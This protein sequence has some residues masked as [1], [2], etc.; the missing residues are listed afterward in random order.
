MLL[1]CSALSVLFQAMLGELKADNHIEIVLYWKISSS[2]GNRQFKKLPKTP[3]VPLL[4]LQFYCSADKIIS[5]I[6]GPVQGRLR[7]G[8][9]S[10]NY[11]SFQGIPYARPPLGDL[12]FKVNAFS[13]FPPTSLDLLVIFFRIQFSL[14]HGT[15]H[16]MLGKKAPVAM[17]LICSLS[18][19]I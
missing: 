8:V 14:C 11:Y 18:T 5:T 15:K 10:G 12:R 4:L 6:Y 19:R 2:D 16:L 17:D 3:S 9:R 1:V 13:S 7:Y